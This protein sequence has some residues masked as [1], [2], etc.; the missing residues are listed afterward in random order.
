MKECG[1]SLK[2]LIKRIR[3]KES[4]HPELMVTHEEVLALNRQSKPKKRSR[5]QRTKV[6]S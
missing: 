1:G 2:E 4:E 5:R 3:A 6:K